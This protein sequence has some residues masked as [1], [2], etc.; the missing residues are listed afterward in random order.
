M[1]GKRVLVL[2]IVVALL[3]GCATTQGGTANPMATVSQVAA[4]ALGLAQQLDNVYAF[5]VAQKAVPD[6]LAAATSALAALDAIAPMVQQ[7][8]AA[9]SGDSI[10]WV[11]FV[12]QAAITA[13]QVFGY[14][15]PL[16]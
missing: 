5:L 13:A 1:K 4:T 16:L 3:A 15:L 7:G 9:L 6:H 8:A 11:Q 12:M 14:V 2:S 10:N